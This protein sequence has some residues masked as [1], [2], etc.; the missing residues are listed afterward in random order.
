MLG[1]PDNDGEL[2]MHEER[3]TE[4]GSSATF[5]EVLHCPQ[6]GG[7]THQLR[8][9]PTECGC[10]SLSADCAACDNTTTAAAHDSSCKDVDRWHT[11]EDN[12]ED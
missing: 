11:T 4:G 7:W 10:V 12:K 6:C 8:F 1:L 5:E 9:I 2:V 3:I